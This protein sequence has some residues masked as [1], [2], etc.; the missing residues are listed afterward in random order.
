MTS[1]TL[2]ARI[3]VYVTEP[4]HP[5]AQALLARNARVV[6]G[7]EDV[8]PEEVRRRVRDVAVILSKTDPVPIGAD[9]IDAAPGL[10]LIAR[11]GSGY[12]NVDVGHAHGPGHRRHQYTG[13]ERRHGCLSTP[14]ASCSPRRAGWCRPRPPAAPARPSALASWGRNCSARRLESSASG[15]SAGRWSSGCPRWGCGLSPTI[16][17]LP[18]ATSSICPLTLV[19]LDTLLR[20]SD[21]VSLHVPLNEQTRSLIGAR[22]LALMKPTAILLNL[23][24]GNVVDE[25]ALHD[26]LK[27]GAIDSAATDVLATEPGDRVG[28]VAAPGQLP[29][30]AAH[31]HGNRGGAE[32]RRHDRGRGDPAI[33]PGR[34]SPPRGQS[35]RARRGPTDVEAMN[36]LFS[37]D[38]RTAVVTGASGGDRRGHCAGIR[39]GR[40]E[41]GP[42][43]SPQCPRGRAHRSGRLQSRRP[44]P[45]LPW[46]TCWTRR[47]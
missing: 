30:A 13:C 4:V 24:R 7:D 22:E 16:L 8:T 35:G 41:P 11:H 37:L 43:L 1:A 14:L 17:A 38:G 6:V 5:E 44:R 27:R 20:E 9:V 40:R 25:R 3:S 42:H 15:R 18:P 45:H 29:G 28:T 10:R 34:D 46:S 36:D 39:P 32:G 26:A 2:S 12:S 47:A 33:F 31:R 19:D 21:V 23:A